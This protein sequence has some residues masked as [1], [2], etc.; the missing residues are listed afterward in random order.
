MADDVIAMFDFVM[1]EKGVRSANEKHYRLV[2]MEEMTAADLE[3]YR[4]ASFD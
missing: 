2:P 3:N 4:N 1:A